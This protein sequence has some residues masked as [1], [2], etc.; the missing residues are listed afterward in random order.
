LSI[1]TTNE[2]RLGRWYREH[3]ASDSQADK[4]AKLLASLDNNQS[5]WLLKKE[6]LQAVM[7]SGFPI[8]FQQFD[9]VSNLVSDPWIERHSRCMFVGLKT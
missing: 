3:S 9:F 1:L 7:D 5:F 2:G 8:A 6:L 4:D